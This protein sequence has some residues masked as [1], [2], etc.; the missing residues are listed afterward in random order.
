ML[1]LRIF[2]II[3]QLC[4]SSDCTLNTTVYNIK[5]GRWRVESGKQFNFLSEGWSASVS[6]GPLNVP[7][8]LC[9]NSWKLYR[10]AYLTLP[11]SCHLS[12][13]RQLP[14]PLICLCSLQS[15]LLMHKKE[16]RKEGPG[17]SKSS[18]Y[19]LLILH[20]IFYYFLFY[21]WLMS[22]TS[23]GRW[24][25][26]KKLVFVKSFK[27][28]YIFCNIPVFNIMKFQTQNIIIFL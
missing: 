16:D 19:F 10:A 20:G 1:L 22:S 7:T 4:A 18:L 26:T 25:N 6:L 2:K 15:V 27:K 23:L 11:L 8:Y 28:S 14:F 13:H 5:S 24:S 3:K 9:F 17:V 12:Y 21:Y